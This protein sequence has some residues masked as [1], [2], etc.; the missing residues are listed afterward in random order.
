MVTKYAYGFF[1]D[2]MQG[3]HDYFDVARWFFFFISFDIFCTFFLDPLFLTDNSILTDIMDGH[4]LIC[5][6]YLALLPLL[7]FLDYLRENGYA[8]MQG[9]FIYVILVGWV[10]YLFY[11]FFFDDIFFFLFGLTMFY[12][13]FIVYEEEDIV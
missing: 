4:D 10:P 13:Y 8:I 1:K 3:G 6:L 11:D 9:M 12:D 7:Y 2:E 5:Y